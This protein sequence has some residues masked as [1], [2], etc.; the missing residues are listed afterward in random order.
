MTKLFSSE[1]GIRYLLIKHQS[2]SLEILKSWL[3][4]PC[5][6]VR[7]LIS[8][9][10]RP[11]LPWAM[12]L[13]ELKQTPDLVL[14]LLKRLRDDESEYVRRSV[15]NHLND[16][17]KNHP[18]WVAEVIADW[19]QVSS[20]N[21]QKL[22]KHAARTLIKQGHPATLSVFGFGDTSKLDV[23]LVLDKQKMKLGETIC[24]RLTINNRS[25]QINQLLID[26]VVYH[27]KA[28]GKKYIKCNC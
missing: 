26:Y 28:N 6:H 2:Q 19:F 27:K 23:S 7:R 9:G 12:Q 22:L 8:E 1:F 11:L 3:N 25:E 17:S 21:R 5:R 14:P 16:I 20:P 4:D 24:L 10:T 15:A 13:V 18:D